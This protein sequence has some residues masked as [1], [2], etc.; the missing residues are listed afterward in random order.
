MRYAEEHFSGPLTLT[1]L[2]KEA[3]MSMSKFTA[4]FKTHT[5]ISAAGYIH[6]LRMDKAL[7]NTSCPLTEAADAAG[8]KHYT[9]FSTAFRE[10]FGVTPSEFRK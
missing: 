5:G 8:Y 10:Q 9:S 7:D 3:A 1:A 2:A 6:R 4:A